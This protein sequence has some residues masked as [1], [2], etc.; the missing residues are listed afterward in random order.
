MA[1]P[2][3]RVIPFDT[4]CE[5]GQFPRYPNNKDICVNIR[6]VDR[7]NSLIIFISHC[8]L[9]GWSG[10][11]GWDPETCPHPD[12]ATHEKYKLCVKGISKVMKNL[13]KGMVR[14][15]VWLDFGCMDQDGNPAGELKQLD[16][17]VRV[18]DCIFTPLYG[19]AELS[20]SI[21]NIY[22]DYKLPAWNGDKFGY[23]SR[24]WCRVEMF[25]AANIP[26]A[27]TSSERL[28]KLQAGLQHHVSNGV[29]PHLLY[30]SRED[31]G[32]PPMILPPLQ[33]SYFKILNPE[34]GHVSVDS[35]RS[36]ISELV[37]FLQPYMKSVQAGYVGEMREGKMHGR[38]VYTDP[39]GNV[40]KGEFKDDTR[41]GKGVYKD[42]NGNEYDGDWVDDKWHGRGVFK[43]GSGDVYEG[44]FVNDKR[45]GR[46]IYTEAN[47]GLYDGEFKNNQKNGRGAYT[48]ADG[49]QYFGDWV[50]DKRHGRGVLTSP[51]NGDYEGDF[52]HDK[53]DGKGIYRFKDGGLY[54]GDWLADD[55]HGKGVYMSPDG[56][57]FEGDFKNGVF[58]EEK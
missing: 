57:V 35:D 38:G 29:R 13:A 37:R 14:C 53:K 34:G 55:M 58:C 9:R 45:H 12:N 42:S 8:W 30:G 11:E 49:V 25:Y 3:I 24:G 44:E 33:N 56:D 22:E 19:V 36:K 23:T 18:S 26:L 31:K 10:A 40:Y 16:E 48:D 52:I 28:S 41:H 20:T 32:C 17:I 50:N 15:Y 47:G 6:D 54:D 7:E 2:P 46:G 51:H 4:F 5:V 1:L 21:S 27:T 43:Y 39:H